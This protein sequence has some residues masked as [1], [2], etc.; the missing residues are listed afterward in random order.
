[1]LNE[2]QRPEAYQEVVLQ[3]AGVP[4]VLSVWAGRPG[5]PVVVFLPGTM[6]HP[7]FYEEFLDALNRAGLTVVGVH[8]QGHG[9]SPRVRVPLTFGTLV[10]NAR[11]AVGWARTA[12]SDR[13]LVLLGSSQGG[14]L[15]MAVAARDHRLDAVVAHNVLD[16]TQPP[17]VQITRLPQSLRH[18]Y[19][20][21]RAGMRVG[22]RLLPRLPVPFDAYLDIDRVTPNPATAE[23][24]YTDPLGLRSYPL[25][26]M[27]S[28]VGA[29]LSGMTDGSIRCP[30]VVIAGVGDPLFPLAYTRQVYDRLT[31]PH[32]ELLVLDSAVHLLFTEDLDTVL[33][34]LLERLLAVSPVDRR[35]R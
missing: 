16:P 14:I 7:L 26:F 5:L 3:S 2:V 29:D 22:G 28:L 19:R 35:S 6:T 13:P 4:I 24:F 20:A 33:P 32:K 30:V 15:A 18:A 21:V 27:A 8:G 31:A 12:F 23:F 11:D 34:P 9:K 17:S 10:T 1:M 25:R